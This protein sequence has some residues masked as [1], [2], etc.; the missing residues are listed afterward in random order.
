MPYDCSN[1]TLWLEMKFGTQD[2]YLYEQQLYYK[3][4]WIV[5]K[6]NSIKTIHLLEHHN[7]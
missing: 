4:P 7:T 6:K 5:S 3:L 2:M 1:D